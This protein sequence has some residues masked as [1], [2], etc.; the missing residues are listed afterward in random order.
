MDTKTKIKLRHSIKVTKGNLNRQTIIT[1]GED[2][3]QGWL[4]I[5]SDSG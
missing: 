3:D 2:T 4:R 5:T 1:P